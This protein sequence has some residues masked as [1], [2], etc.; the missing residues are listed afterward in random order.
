LEGKNLIIIFLTK[1]SV[2]VCLLRDCINIAPPLHLYLYMSISLRKSE[3]INL[4][5]QEPGL[6]RI[7]VGLGWELLPSS[8]LDLDS[9]VFIISGNNK[10]ISDEYFV[11]YNNLKSPDGAVQHTGDNRTGLGDGDDEVILANLDLVDSQVSELFFLVSV[12]DG[13][14]RKHTFGMLQKAYIRLYDMDAKREVA[15]FNLEDDHPKATEVI[16]GKLIRINGDWK[17]LAD[18]TGTNI[19]LQGYVDIYT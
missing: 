12:H 15:R 5:R 16:F 11:F 10:V 19:G 4:T 8:P 9:S 2:I 18:G 1:I 6:K 14:E 7:L 3:S 13:V 17:F